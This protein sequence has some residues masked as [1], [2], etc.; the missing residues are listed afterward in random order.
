MYLA[1]KYDSGSQLILDS[2]TS[3]KAKIGPFFSYSYVLLEN[4]I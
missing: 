1:I 2:F 3:K 4:K